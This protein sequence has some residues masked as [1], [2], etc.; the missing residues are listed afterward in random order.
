MSWSWRTLKRLQAADLT[1]DKFWSAISV[2]NTKPYLL[3]KHLMGVEQLVS[4]LLASDLSNVFD[5]LVEQSDC[6]VENPKTTFEN[7]GL[8]NG[9]NVQVEVWK[10]LTKRPVNWNDYLRLS[11]FGK[12]EHYLIKTCYYQILQF[13]NCFR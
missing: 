9:E 3:I 11:I 12:S 8:S 10:L 4:D 1:E 13:I 2:W 6:W 7:L 5:L